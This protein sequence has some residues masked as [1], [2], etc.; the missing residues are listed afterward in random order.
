MQIAQA[1]VFISFDYDHDDDLKVLL[2]GQAR[3]PQSPFLVE[4]W[5]IKE[6]S[7]DWK[8]R[9]RS[10]I[11]RVDQ[12]IVICGTH[13]DTATGVNTEVRQSRG[14]TVLPPCRSGR[15]RQHDPDGCPR[16]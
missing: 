16:E 8:A 6:A 5:S 7:P 4:D 3:N 2:V 15:R 1:R 12:V 9:A 11:R 14:E 13:T 10:R